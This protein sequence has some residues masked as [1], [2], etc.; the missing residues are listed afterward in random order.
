MVRTR[1]EPEGSLTSNGGV[2]GGHSDPGMRSSKGQED[3]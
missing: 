2:G 3:P 1:P